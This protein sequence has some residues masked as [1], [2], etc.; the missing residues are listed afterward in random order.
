MYVQS[1]RI[2]YLGRCAL[3]MAG[4]SLAT[5]LPSHVP[6]ATCMEDGSEEMETREPTRR[7]RAHTDTAPRPSSYLAHQLGIGKIGTAK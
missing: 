3:S 1:C 5:Y 2:S 6:L 7:E 4:L